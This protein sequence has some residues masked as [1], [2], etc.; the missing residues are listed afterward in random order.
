MR[1]RQKNI[2]FTYVPTLVD[3][4]PDLDDLQEYFDANE[5]DSDDSVDDEF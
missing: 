2:V 1:N 5:N 4:P 3:R